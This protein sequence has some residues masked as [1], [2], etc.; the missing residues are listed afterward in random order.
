MVVSL[1]AVRTGLLYPNEIHLILISVRGWVDSSAIV[2]PEVLRHWKIQMTPS[3]IE[4][5]TCRFVAQC[6]NHYATVRPN[7]Q[8]DSPKF[9]SANTWQRQ[10]YVKYSYQSHQ[11]MVVGMTF[12]H[13]RHYYTNWVKF[14]HFWALYMNEACQA[15]IIIS[16]NYM[17]A[18]YVVT[19]N[20]IFIFDSGQC[21][22]QYWFIKSNMAINF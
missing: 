15:A 20:K 18:A 7:I 22:K 13:I 21:R 11:Y 3:G 4:P 8:Y 16:A 2:R 10:P 6:L 1:S 5:A 17:P 12:K 9:R 14:L 19:K